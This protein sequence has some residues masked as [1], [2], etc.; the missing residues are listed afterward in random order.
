LGYGIQGRNVNRQIVIPIVVNGYFFDTQGLVNAAEYYMD[1]KL[2]S[3]RLKSRNFTLIS[4]DCWGAELYHALNLEYT[5]P[6][7]GLFVPPSHFIKLIKNLKHYMAEPIEFVESSIYRH[8]KFSDYPIGLVGKDVEIH[9]LHY[10]SR[11]D[12]ENKWAKRKFR[13][14]W[15]NLFF[16]IDLERGITPEDIAEIQKLHENNILLFGREGSAIEKIDVLKQHKRAFYFQS[17]SDNGVINFKNTVGGI[18]YIGWLNGKSGRKTRTNGILSWRHRCQLYI[19][20]IL[21]S[22]KSTRA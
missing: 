20:N 22:I 2:N 3:N 19:N 1:K 4:D 14:F 15:D 21:D 12:A 11:E 17:W 16:K 10:R 13:I 6:F 5:T 8:E 7:V 18:D 9:F